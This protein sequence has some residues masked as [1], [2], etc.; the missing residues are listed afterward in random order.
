MRHNSQPI[1]YIVD[2]LAISPSRLSPTEALKQQRLRWISGTYQF[3]NLQNVLKKNNEVVATSYYRFISSSHVAGRLKLQG[4]MSFILLNWP[5]LLFASWNNFPSVRQYLK[6]FAIYVYLKFP[7]LCSSPMSTL[8][9]SSASR[10]PTS[11]ASAPTPRNEQLAPNEEPNEGESGHVEGGNEEEMPEENRGVKRKLTSPVWNDF[12]RKKVNGAW[13][14]KCLNCGSL[15]SGETRNGTSHLSSYLKS[16]IYKKRVDGKVQSSLRFASSEEGQVSVENYVFDLEV[17]RKA[18]YSMIILHEYPLS[19]VD[20]TGFRNFFVYVP[21]PHTGKVLAE[22]LYKSLQS[23]DLDC[24]V[25][26]LTLDNCSTNDKMVE[27]M[28]T[29]FIENIRD[30]CAY[31]TATPK[32][33]ERFEKTAQQQKVELTKTLCLDCK[34]RWNSTYNM[35]SVALPYKKVFDRLKQL[36]NNFVCSPSIEEWNFASY[37]CERLGM[38]SEL[39]KL[40][41]GTKHGIHGLMAIAVI[42]DPR[43][44][45][46]LLEAC[47]ICLFGEDDAEKHVDETKK[48]LVRLMDQYSK[49]IQ[50]TYYFLDPPPLRVIFYVGV[51]KDYSDREVSEIDLSAI[52]TENVNKEVGNTVCWG[53]LTGCAR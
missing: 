40:F 52:G 28:Q 36:D 7:S 15:L 19:I 24:K 14:A 21:C 50:N 11:Q 23:W 39:T 29:K 27:Y 30:S 42:L 1:D 4:E 51:M 31:W 26:T 16:C 9:N 48:I 45:L 25:Y 49:N 47:Y 2:S 44:K 38:F 17:A 20:H 6:T 32:R 5:S 33:Y 34:T 46:D 43:G 10:P 13:K 12:V 8:R 37:V 35:L 53:R 22:A 18:L 3:W 41:S